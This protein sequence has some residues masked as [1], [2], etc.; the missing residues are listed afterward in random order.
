[1]LPRSDKVYVWVTV[2]AAA[3]VVI[4]SLIAAANALFGDPK[5]RPAYE[6]APAASLVPPP[7]QQ[8]VNIDNATRPYIADVDYE[9]L[10]RNTRLAPQALL[11]DDWEEAADKLR[12]TP[13]AKRALRRDL[14]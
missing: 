14:R 8:I 7:N 11:S 13:G 3:A 6:S 4:I 1:M 10:H 9:F 12:A 5:P 2:A